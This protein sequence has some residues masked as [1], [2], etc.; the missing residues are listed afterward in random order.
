MEEGLLK[1]RVNEDYVNRL[2]GEEESAAGRSSFTWGVLAEEGK[3][4]GYIAGP[5]VGVALALKLMLVVSIMMV[6]HVDVLSLSSTALATSFCSVSGF[7]V[8]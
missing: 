3:K 6:G 5:M 1:K 4:A 8:I 7:S 2:L